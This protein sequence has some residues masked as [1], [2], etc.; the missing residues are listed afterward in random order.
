MSPDSPNLTEELQLRSTLEFSKN[1]RLQSGLVLFQL[2]F[3]FSGVWIFAVLSYGVHNAYWESEGDQ[4]IREIFLGSFFEHIQLIQVF[5]II[6]LTYLVLLAHALVHGLVYWISVREIPKIAFSLRTILQFGFPEKSISRNAFLFAHGAPM[7][8]L[9]LL[10][11]VSMFFISGEKALVLVFLISVHTTACA[12]DCFGL[13]TGL[14]HSPNAQ[15]LTDG[16]DINIIEQIKATD[17]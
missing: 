17:Q 14:R 1:F 12:R 13:I 9:H 11:I 3:F 16:Y 8:L 2:L 7:L 4:L 6:L 5:E 15:V 10:G